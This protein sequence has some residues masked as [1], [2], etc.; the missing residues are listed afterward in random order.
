MKKLVIWAIGMSFLLAA[1]ACDGPNNGSGCGEIPIW[2]DSVPTC[3]EAV[4]DADGMTHE[5]TELYVNWNGPGA[6][7]APSNVPGFGEDGQTRPLNA[8]SWSM[9]SFGDH[10]YVGV[11]NRLFDSSNDADI[12]EGGE[13]WRYQPGPTV[14]SGSWQQEVAAGFGNLTNVGIRVMKVY[15][16]HLFAGTHNKKGTQLWRRSMDTAASPGKWEPISKNGFGDRG[17]TASRSMAVFNGKLYI[18]TVNEMAGARL[19]EFDADTQILSRVEQI[20]GPT[21]KVKVVSELVPYGE[22]M[23]IFAWDNANGLSAYRMDRQQHIEY[24]GNI[25]TDSTNSGIMSSAIYNGKLYVGTVNLNTGAQ[26]F[27]LEDPSLAGQENVTWKRVGANVFQPTE[28]YLWRMQVFAGQ[29]YI[30]TWNPYDV[31]RSRSWEKVGATLYRMDE[32]EGFCQVIG[33]GRLIEEGFGQ[34]ENFGIRSMTE[35]NGRLYIGTAQVYKVEPGSDDSD[36]AN[37]DG[38][39]VWEFE[40]M[41]EE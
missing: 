35:Y 10:L 18:G 40:K 1:S 30:G 17:N 16:N 19:Y 36:R 7:T 28:K 23:W 8:Y 34:S 15:N 29:L 11:Y 38:T 3:G 4:I 41:A 39:E 26:L 33:D 5:S 21:R 22:H 31:I 24:I 13:V 12:S 14:N 20:G 6:P 25:G 32:N 9:A 27:V 37:R 2:P